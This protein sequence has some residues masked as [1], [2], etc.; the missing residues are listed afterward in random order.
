MFVK[1][2]SMQIFDHNTSFKTI[3]SAVIHVSIYC[4]P[5]H[6]FKRFLCLK[7]T[8]FYILPSLPFYHTYSYALLVTR[9]HVKYRVSNLK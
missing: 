1:K 8:H 6:F 2:T 3:F 4:L 7:G 9:M 5:T